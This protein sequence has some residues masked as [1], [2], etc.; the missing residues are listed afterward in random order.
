[1][2][3]SSTIRTWEIIVAAFVGSFFL[4]LAD[5]VINKPTAVTTRIAVELGTRFNPNFDTPQ[6]ELVAFLIL[7]ALGLGL[8]FVNRPRSRRSAFAQSTSVIAVLFAMNT[9]ATLVGAAS[10]QTV[11]LGTSAQVSTTRP[12]AFG[13]LGI[14]TLLTGQSYTT[15]QN[16]QLTGATTLPCN[17]TMQIGSQSYCAVSPE[18]LAANVADPS[19][20][21]ALQQA[22]QLWILQ[23]ATQ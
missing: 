3:A 2:P 1:M 20:L 23:P 12:R 22:Q 15:E 14:G 18:A 10:A 8:C 9:G 7:F 6:F 11:D 4:T 16:I 17:E 21:Q 5:V 13:P 19:Q